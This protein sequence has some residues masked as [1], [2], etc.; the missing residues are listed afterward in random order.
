MSLCV[1]LELPWRFE[2]AICRLPIFVSGIWIYQNR[3]GE[4][5][6]RWGLIYSVALLCTTGLYVQHLIHTYVVFYMLFPIVLIFSS[7][8]IS[9]FF[10]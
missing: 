10:K 3:S 7:H 1:I 4:V 9:R 8:I 5:I 6:R 2:P